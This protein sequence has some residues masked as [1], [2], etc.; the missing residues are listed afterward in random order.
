MQFACT[1]SAQCQAVQ[2]ACDRLAACLSSKCLVN[3][4]WVVFAQECLAH[5][6]A[7]LDH[8]VEEVDIQTKALVLLGVLIQVRFSAAAW[9]CSHHMGCSSLKLRSAANLY[10]SHGQ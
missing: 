7:A 1:G 2:H 8:H 10:P 3:L 4:C 9:E 6:I 5:I